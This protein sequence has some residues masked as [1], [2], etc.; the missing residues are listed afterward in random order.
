MHVLIAV[1]LV[2]FLLLWRSMAETLARLAAHPAA[3]AIA[4]LPRIPQSIVPVA[5]RFLDL[6]GPVAH[7]HRLAND[8]NAVGQ[9]TRSDADNCPLDLILHFELEENPRAPWSESRTWK[10][11]LKQATA[12]RD[13]LQ[14][15]WRDEPAVAV[16]GASISTM[17]EAT[18]SPQKSAFELRT[19]RQEELV[20]MPVVLM[21]RGMLVRLWDNLLFVMGAVVL[22]VCGESMYSFPQRGKLNAL[23]WC[24]ILVGVAAALYVFVQMERDKVLSQLT[25]GTPDRINWDRDFIS[26]LVVYALVPLLGLFATQ[27]PAIGET[28]LHWLAP[29]E[30]ALP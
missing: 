3:G 21:L 28:V 18:S 10:A 25:N 14:Q 20:F 2:Q 15:R 5:P 7:W 24:D 30:R 11:L 9:P 4:R 12:V 22:I 17:P 29:V 6:S 1:A 23:V 26:K 19:E 13:A 8:A 27:F 16:M